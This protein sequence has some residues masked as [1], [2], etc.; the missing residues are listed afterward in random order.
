MMASCSSPVKASFKNSLLSHTLSEQF[1]H[2]VSTSQSWYLLPSSIRSAIRNASLP[3]TDS[4]L[5][6]MGSFSSFLSAFPLQSVSFCQYFPKYTVSHVVTPDSSTTGLES[7]A[8]FS[9]ALIMS[10]PGVV[11]N[12]TLFI[13]I[14]HTSPAANIVLL[15]VLIILMRPPYYV[16]LLYSY[17]TLKIL[18]IFS[19]SWYSYYQL[20]K[21][22]RIAI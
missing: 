15:N 11:P 7:T 20:F 19:E 4:T 18:Q 10:V 9:S 16:I 2:V 5:H 6:L 1:S 12:V 3:L 17:I 8:V 14:V 22:Q 13:H 21:C